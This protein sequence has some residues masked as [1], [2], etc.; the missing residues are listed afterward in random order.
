MIAEEGIW[1]AYG[2]NIW[3]VLG[4]VSKTKNPIAYVQRS[5]LAQSIAPGT[6][7]STT[8]NTDIFPWVP[9]GKG[10]EITIDPLS[11]FRDYFSLPVIDGSGSPIK[12]MNAFEVL[13]GWVAPIAIAIAA[14]KDSDTYMGVPMEY[15]VILSL[16]LP[17]ITR[18]MIDI[19]AQ[20]STLTLG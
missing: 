17:G 15:R 14:K 3:L 10:Q 9:D 16:M 6:P 11:F 7:F 8:F 13:K 1:L 18:S 12:L 2:F 20:R 4:E 19:L 5:V